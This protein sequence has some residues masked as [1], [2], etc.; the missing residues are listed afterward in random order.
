MYEIF[1]CGFSRNKRNENK[2]IRKKKRELTP[3][4]K[5]KLQGTSKYRE[6]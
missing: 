4:R 2:I 5:K 6:F 1:I 3:K